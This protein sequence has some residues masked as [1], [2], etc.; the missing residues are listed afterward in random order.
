[1]IQHRLPIANSKLLA[2]VFAVALV[3][4][5]TGI[6]LAAWAPDFSS[7]PYTGNF[8]LSTTSDAQVGFAQYVKWNSSRRQAMQSDTNPQFDMTADCTTDNPGGDRLAYSVFFTN[9]PNSGVQVW[10]DCGGLSA[11]E[12]VDLKINKSSVQAETAYY[13]Q[14]HYKKNQYG[15]SGAINFSYQRD[16]SPTHDHLDKVLYSN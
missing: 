16:N 9:I 4:M 7:A 11:K 15:V 14:V 10:N 12:E 13:Y 8:S 6:A 1:M 5:I 3:L 2:P